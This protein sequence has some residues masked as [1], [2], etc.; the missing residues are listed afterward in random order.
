MPLVA[1][2]AAGSEDCLSVNVW[3]PDPAP[4]NPLPVMVFIHGGAWFSGSGAN[5]FGNAS[6]APLY[7]GRALVPT[8][9]VA[10]VTLNYRLG[11]LGFLA[12]SALSAENSSASS[13]NYGLLDQQAALQWVQANIAAFGGDRNN[14]T[15]FGESAGGS[16]VCYHMVA[17]A[18][19][20]LFHR[21]IVESGSCVEPLSTLSAA[22][23]KGGAFAN[24]MGCTDTS[25][26]LSCLRA[27]PS[28]HIRA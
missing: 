23:A 11:W 13:G 10:V 24:L 4:T 15:L 5:L 27:E 12:H 17:P 9:N 2:N 8:G 16:S 28:P 21:G 1:Y 6:D 3:T 19:Q 20:G 18:S 7:T 26:A 25:S 22:E 14:V